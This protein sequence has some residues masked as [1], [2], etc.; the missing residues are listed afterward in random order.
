[1]KHILC[2]VLSLLLCCM[3]VG[4]V[5]VEK[6]GTDNDTKSVLENHVN[7]DDDD[8][9]QKTTST[10]KPKETETQKPQNTTKPSEVMV[11]IPTSGS[12]YHSK[13]GCS[14]M[15]NPT[16]ITKSQA[17]ARGYEPCSRCH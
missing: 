8:V 7:T 3:S 4:C 2:L 15:K 6:S 1:M 11:W 13:A 12:K 9:T 5:E 17:E 14:N 10:A 16:Q